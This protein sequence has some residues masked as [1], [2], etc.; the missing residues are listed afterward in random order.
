[1]T[2]GQTSSDTSGDPT[3]TSPATIRTEREEGGLPERP[4]GGRFW[5]LQSFDDEEDND[6]GVDSPADERNLLRY[7]QT[8]STVSGRDL[9]E[10]PSDLARRARKR[11]NRQRAQSMAARAA[12][13][14]EDEETR[15]DG[16]GVL[17]RRGPITKFHRIVE[18]TKQTRSNGDR[19]TQQVKVGGVVAGRAFRKLLGFAWKKIEAGAPVVQRRQPSATMNGD[20]GQNFNPGRGGFNHGRGGFQPRGGFGGANGRGGYAGRGCQG[21]RGGRGGQGFVGGQN[22]S[23]GRGGHGNTGNNSFGRNFIHGEASGTAGINNGQGYRKENWG[24][25]HSNFQRGAAHNGNRFGYAAPQQRW[26]EGNNG[27]RGGYQ[28]RARANPSGGVTRGGIDADLLHQTVQAV[29][30]AVTAAQNAPEVA[31]SAQ[32]QVA[33]ATEAGVPNTEVGVSAAAPTVAQQQGD[34]PQVTTAM[35]KE[36][37]GPGP[38]KKKKEEKMGC[39]RC[40]KPGHY[41]DDCPTPF[42]DLCESVNHS[43]AACHLLHAPKPTAILHG[44]ANEALMFFELSCGAFKA[45]VENPKLAKVTIDGDAMTIPEIIEQLKKIVPHEKFN[46]EVFHYKENIFRVKLPS[47]LEVQRLKNFGTYICTDRE[48]CLSFDLWSSVEDPLYML[49]EV[50]VRVSGLPSDMRS[51]YLSLWGVGTLFGK[52]LDVDMAY[53]RKNRVLRTKIGC[54]DHRLI[55]A[56]S[57]MFIR[58]GF[59]KLKFEVETTEVSQEVTMVE[60][61]NDNGG[62]GD[63]YNGQGN[64]AGGN[65]MDMDPKRGDGDATSNNNDIGETNGNN[66]GDGMMEQLEHFDAI[67]IG[68]LDVK[69]SPSGTLQFDSNLSKNSPIFE[70]LLHVQKLTLDDENCTDFGADS[71]LRGSPSGLHPVGARE[72]KQHAAN[73]Q[74][75]SISPSA[76]CSPLRQG[77][78]GGTGQ[79]APDTH[80]AVGGD[81]RSS[82]RAATASVRVGQAKA[83]AGSSAPDEVQRAVLREVLPQKIQAARERGSGLQKSSGSHDAAMIGHS[84]KS[85]AGSSV[86][87]GAAANGFARKSTLVSSLEPTKGDNS[88]VL[89]VNTNDGQGNAGLKISTGIASSSKTKAS[90]M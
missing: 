56:E 49:P 45:K 52:T 11:I 41:I 60:V 75:S 34:T 19:H 27:G 46:W 61:N 13:E 12:I 53:T 65:V 55:P 30:A 82:G 21:Q 36:D 69:L 23:G 2:V 58:R 17:A 24:G 79:P 77:E 26:S 37:E 39:F 38:S 33:V 18:I 50:W 40:K 28:Y 83:E 7:Y 31:G 9:S 85:T 70:S 29:V 62:N 87:H 67:K 57:D 84:L 59:Y 80:A 47:K 1:M 81:Q 66:G 20:E 78:K 3:C 15:S 74:R 35:G 14:L 4:L 42:C 73:G 5:V 76:P 51:D 6:D 54:L 43:T 10:K 32:V 90:K 68:S 16:N 25:G 88:E 63:A 72:M 48:S 89:M 22:F 71:L 86:L 44:Y 8:P 64:N